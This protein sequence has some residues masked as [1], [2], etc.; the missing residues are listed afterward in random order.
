MFIVGWVRINVGLLDARVNENLL[1]TR[2]QA[3]AAPQ[4]ESQ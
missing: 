2:S 4:I 3:A 1:E